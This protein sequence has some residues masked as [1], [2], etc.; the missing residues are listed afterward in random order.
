M[1]NNVNIVTP[2]FTPVGPT[3]F[4]DAPPEGIQSNQQPWWSGWTTHPGIALT[5]H[6]V[7][8]IFHAAEWGQPLDQCDLF[9]DVIEND[10]HLRSLYETRID[11]VAG[12][13]WILQAG[14]DSPD[15]IR[16]AEM[17]AEAMNAVENFGAM[18]E[19]ELDCNAYGYAG[20]EML[21]GKAPNG[22]IAPTYF[23]NVPHRQWTF[24]IASR[25]RIILPESMIGEYLEPGRY[26]FN[27]RTHRLTVRAGYMRTATWWALFKRMAIRDWVTFVS[28][29]G[30]PFVV[31]K[32]KDDVPEIE[33]ATLRKA[34]E[35]IG[36]DGYAAFN[37][38]C[39]IEFAKADQN[40]NQDVHP[41]LAN[42]C[43]AEM[44]KLITGA[45]L[46]SG[47][48]TSTGSYALGKV[49]ENVSFNIVVA[50]AKRM[51]DW[52]AQ[53]VSKPFLQWNGLTGKPPK[54]KIH[55]IQ[56][57]SPEVRMDLWSRAAN[58]LGLRC[59][60]DQ[61]RQ[62]FQLKTPAGNALHGTK[63]GGSIGVQKTSVGGSI[64]VTK[65]PAA[66]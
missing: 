32:Y 43:N 18:I 12:K 26:F 29:F 33:K 31:G 41:A 6:R 59:D 23:Y 27:A 63:G 35:M 49:H 38:A 34:V 66:Q 11:T 55:V 37:E 19:H 65:G 53:Q 64:D 62:E 15:D 3:T 36:R 22:A 39:T 54:L 5:P 48:G 52:F 13:D 2:F 46:T 30:L 21:W 58:E 40:A 47:E 7:L 1:A 56:E 20:A 24:D 17:L 60:E 9:E 4:P 8:S 10:G 57:A 50:D 44:S 28:R 42:F 61:F 25:P 16:A 45:T 51:G 14:G